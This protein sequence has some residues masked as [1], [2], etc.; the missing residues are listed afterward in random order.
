MITNEW[1]VDVANVL[2][3][4]NLARI[5]AALEQD[6]IIVEHLHYA[7]GSSKDTLLFGSF[8]EFMEHLTTKTKP[9]D[10]FYIYALH[11]L[12]DRKLYL[13]RAKYPDAQ[14]RTPPGGPY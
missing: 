8:E 3:P 14:G 7:G 9:G 11:E 10:L 4:A 1:V 12:Y 5:A 13:L 6:Y 2:V